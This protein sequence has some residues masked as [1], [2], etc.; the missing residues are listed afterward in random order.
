[1]RMIAWLTLCA[2]ALSAPVQAQESEAQRRI[3][4]TEH[5]RILHW[6][7]HDD[8]A[9]I[10]RDAGNTAIT[11]LGSLL[12]ME[13]EERID[14]YI[15]RSQGEFDELTGVQNTPWVIG[16]AIPSRLRVV[17]KPRG[18]QRLPDL[19]AHELAHIMLDLRM[20]EAAHRLPRWLHEGIAKYAA[21][22]FDDNDRRVIAD[23]ALSDELLRIDDLEAAFG[24]DRD[25]VSLAYA[26][27][28]TLVQY[29]SDIRPARGISPLLEELEQGRDLRLALGLAFHRPVPEMEREWLEQVRTGY[30]QHVARPMSEA[31]IGAMFVIAFAIAWVMVRRRSARIRER[32][33][34]EEQ[35]RETGSG[36]PP[37]PYTILRAPME[38]EDPVDDDD[39]P[40]IE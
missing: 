22:D 27:S 38:R 20:G 15:V 4:G 10:A 12:N 7:Q 30:V 13:L 8:L 23:A 24:G 6:P 29:L 34:R 11:R 37:G 31:L 28:Y 18:P 40:V 39:R 32:M 21:Q 9:V 36:L 1:M 5:L 25:E 19:I 14:I 17:V 33:K 3:L 26:Q 16:R 2:L 35:L